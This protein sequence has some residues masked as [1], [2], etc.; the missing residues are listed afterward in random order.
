MPGQRI[1]N[2]SLSQIRPWPDQPRKHF[3]QEKIAALSRSIKRVGQLEPMKV[4]K[5]EGGGGYMI[6]DGERRYR[7]LKLLGQDTARVIIQAAGSEAEHFLKALAS[8]FCREGHSIGEIAR[9]VK[10]IVD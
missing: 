9:S 4:R 8:N 1:I 5:A 10:K 7:A 2:I 6:I 3:D